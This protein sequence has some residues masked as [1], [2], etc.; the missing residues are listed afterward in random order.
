MLFRP[1]SS[2]SGTPMTP[3]IIHTTKQTMKASV[4]AT[5]TDQACADTLAPPPT[6]VTFAAELMSFS[7]CRSP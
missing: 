5:S 1:S 7:S 6:A 4:L 2:R 3:N